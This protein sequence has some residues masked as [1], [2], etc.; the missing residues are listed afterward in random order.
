MNKFGVV[1]CGKMGTALMIAMKDVLNVPILCCDVYLEVANKLANALGSNA[2]ATDCVEDIAQNC[3]VVL[4]SV[5]PGVACGI[6]KRLNTG[7]SKIIFSIVAGLSSTDMKKAIDNGTEAPAKCEV[8]RMMPNTPALVGASAMVILKSGLNTETQK[9]AENI[10]SK[11]GECYFVENESLMDAVTG[12]SGS[13]PALF[14]MMAEALA[15]AGVAEGLPRNLALALARQTMLGTA[16]LLE[17]QHPAILKENVMSPGGT[18]AAG[19]LA[20]EKAGFRSAAEA[21]VRAATQKSR[22]TN[23]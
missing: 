1:G 17:V 22:E 6:L 11:T 21:F 19:V 13:G 12:L 9:L 3:D 10:F 7:I 16:K 15:D 18:T 4:L 8:V 14:A 23:H 2:T 20:A 5:K